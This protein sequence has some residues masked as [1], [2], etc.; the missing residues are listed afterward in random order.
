[1]FCIKCEKKTKNSYI[2]E[3]SNIK[4]Y[5]CPDCSN[6]NNENSVPTEYRKSIEELINEFGKL[7]LLAEKANITNKNKLPLK[8]R[9][10][11]ILVR[12]YLKK[13]RQAS[14]NQEK[15]INEKKMNRA[16][17]LKQGTTQSVGKSVSRL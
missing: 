17:D 15:Y 2:S 6:S 11:S 14:L 12:D 1:M 7:M 9:K 13:F 16:S 10:Q 5:L 3:N 8:V 4:I